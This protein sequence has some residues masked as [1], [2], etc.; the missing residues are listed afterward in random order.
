MQCEDALKLV[1][2]ARY[3]GREPPQEA[4]DVLAGSECQELLEKSHRLDALLSLNEAH[5]PGPGFD[6]RF[7]AMLK[8]E[9]ARRERRWIAPILGTLTV[10]S[11]VAL[12]LVLAPGAPAPT[13]ESE[14]SEI[15]ILQELDLLEELD[16]V[17]QLDEVE[18][19]EFLAALDSD[20][21][22]TFINEAQP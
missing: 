18:T 5:S 22:D 14:P 10:G 20:T 2:E 9:K 19:F 6:T 3:E 7:F 12:A 11:A 21:L 13:T 16:V 17:E 8:E 4:L 15:A 1:V